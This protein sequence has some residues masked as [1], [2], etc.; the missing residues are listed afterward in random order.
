MNEERRKRPR[1]HGS[2]AWP[3]LNGRRARVTS[4]A[5]LPPF[6]SRSRA[7]A[8]PDGAVRDRPLVLARRLA[9]EEWHVLLQHCRKQNSNDSLWKLAHIGNQ[10]KVLAELGFQ[11]SKRSH[12]LAWI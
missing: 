3:K 6:R 4:A 12:F 10:V 7:L 5:G 2:E 9:N 11:S 8:A 1:A